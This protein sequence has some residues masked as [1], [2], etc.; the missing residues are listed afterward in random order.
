MLSILSIEYIERPAWFRKQMALR[1]WKAADV[2]WSSLISAFS[3]L[4]V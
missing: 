4:L 1:I 2:S 3:C